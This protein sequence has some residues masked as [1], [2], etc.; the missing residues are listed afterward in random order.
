[1]YRKKLK[2]L[3]VPTPPK[4][5]M[6]INCYLSVNASAIAR[7]SR[8]QIPTEINKRRDKYSN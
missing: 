6:F 8:F 1:M 4:L 5:T 3:V 7:M 2:F